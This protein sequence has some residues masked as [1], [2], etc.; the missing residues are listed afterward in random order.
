[1][2]WSFGFAVKIKMICFFFFLRPTRFLSSQIL[3]CASK[4]E[5]E[6][7]PSGQH[8]LFANGFFRDMKINF[9]I[10]LKASLHGQIFICRIISQLRTLSADIPATRRGL[11]TE[12]TTGTT[13]TTATTRF[14]R[15][16]KWF[17]AVARAICSSL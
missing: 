14:S 4:T 1:M 11:F 17:R 8:W 7:S 15:F 5:Y 12:Y 3:N 13:H 10:A 9:I 2:F 16:S 6:A